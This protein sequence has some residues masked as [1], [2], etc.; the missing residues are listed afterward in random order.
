LCTGGES[1]TIII[2]LGNWLSIGG[3]DIENLEIWYDAL[4]QKILI[5]L[6]NIPNLEK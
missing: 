1:Y 6:V 4:F 3:G 5:V 2:P